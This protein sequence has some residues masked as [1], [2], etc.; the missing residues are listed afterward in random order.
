MAVAKI[1]CP[2]CGATLK[3]AKPLTPG[4]KVRC[5][6]CDHVFVVPGAEDEEEQEAPA[7]KA[8][9]KAATGKG[10]RDSGSGRK[11]PPAEEPA[12]PPKK[13]ADEDEEGGV[14]GVVQEPKLE[15]DG[16]DEED[17]KPK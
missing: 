3:P 10:T 7:R 17:S 15:G 4:K 1:D 16:E 5:P 12:P 13:K 9:A 8:P 6:K 11:S 2:E 14:Y